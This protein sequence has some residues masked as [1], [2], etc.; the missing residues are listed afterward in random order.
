MGRW[1]A[2]M[3][4]VAALA[5]AP[6]G[7]AVA[8]DFEPHQMVSGDDLVSALD[9]D[10]PQG[11]AFI[12]GAMSILLVRSYQDPMFW[13]VPTCLAQTF[14]GPRQI[15]PGVYDYVAALPEDR[16][17]SAQ[18]GLAANAVMFALA[19]YCGQEVTD[20]EFGASE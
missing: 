17:R 1:M 5:S 14:A 13:W 6:T 10:D 4:G 18:V 3:C 2:A 15:A 16:G 12:A 19:D 20:L 8:Q 9:A 7:A 11:M